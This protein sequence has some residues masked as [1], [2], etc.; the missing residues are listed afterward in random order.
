MTKPLRVW[1]TGCFAVVMAALGGGRAAAA[2]DRHGEAGEI[3]E[4]RSSRYSVGETLQRLENCAAS[5][6]FAVFARVDTRAVRHGRSEGFA[7]IV[8]ESSRGGTPVLMY[9]ADAEP[10]VPLAVH[11]RATAAGHSEVWIASAVWDELPD[12]L[13]RDLSELPALVDDALA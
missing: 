6:G 1:M 2:N 4:L 9:T 13:V 5:H 11:V 7:A 12:E 10:D 8:F 3:V